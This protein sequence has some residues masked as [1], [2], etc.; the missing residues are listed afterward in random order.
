MG[1]CYNNYV[2]I[3]SS[4]FVNAKPELVLKTVFG[5]DSFR[6]SQKEIINNVLEKKDTLV[7]MPTGGGKSI[8]YQIPALIME[9]LT[10]VVSPLISLMQDQVF[11]LESAGIHSVFL[12]S[13]LNR[14]QYIAAVKDIKSGNVK[15]V[16][17]SPE[18]LATSRVRDVL[19]ESDLNVSCITIDE[20]H[21]VSEWGHDFRPDYMEICTIR[22]YFPDAVML[23]LTATATEMV[24]K[25]IVKNLGMKKPSIF[26]S[27]FNRGNIFLEVQQKK[28]PL[29]QVI[30]CIKQH[31]GDSGIIY[32][33]SRRQVDEL[34]EALDKRGYSVLSYHAGLTD[35]VRAKN[36][37]KFIKDQVQIIVA[38]VA[39]GMGI[40]KPNVRF[41]INY[42]MPKSIEEYYQEIGRAGRDGL[43]STA[44]LL[45]SAGDCHKIRFFFDEAA[46]PQKSEILLQGMMKFASSRKCRRQSLLQYFGEDYTPTDEEGC[47]DICSGEKIPPADV[48]IP[49]QKLLCCIIRTQERFGT[50]YIIDILLGS[51]NK[52]ILENGHNMLSTWGIGTEL[53]KDDWLVLVDMMIG[54]NYIRKYGEYSVL[55][56]TEDGKSLLATREKVFFPIVISG[57]SDDSGFGF[58]KKNSEKPA[59]IVHKKTEKIIAEKPAVDDE[60]A[61][62]LITKLKAWRKRKAEDMNVPPY[63]VFGDKTLL[64]LVAKKPKDKSELLSIY[65]IGEAKIE[66]FGSALLRILNEP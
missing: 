48:T 63:I 34:T 4:T 44:L 66:N 46:D 61:E 19:S 54:S 7:V 25:D 1:I 5:Y 38:T 11:S 43:P 32:C 9:G 50:N 21:C 39:F 58:P 8:C 52:R 27:S 31:P 10:I 24:R 28:N 62:E 15:I 37:D 47:C 56:L 49:V 36:Q 33:F 12:N 60:A 35:E 55:Q 64:D 20:A 14:E 29:Q 26:I 40:N 13:S 17:V 51:R 2:K 59:F 30:N 45:Y 18:G 53:S 23:A 3:N 16:Y 22:R 6:P 57:K 65:G 42:D 41:V